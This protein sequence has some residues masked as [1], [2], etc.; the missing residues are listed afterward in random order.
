MFSMGQNGP[1]DALH[2]SVTRSRAIAR[3]RWILIPF[4]AGTAALVPWPQTI[5]DRVYAAGLYPHLQPIVTGVTNL[6]PFAILDL[7]VAGAFAVVVIAG[8]RNWSRRRRLAGALGATIVTALN[9]AAGAYLAF[10]VLWGFNYQRT[11]PAV[12]YGVDS[13]RVTPARVAEAA[14]AAATA[15]NRDYVPTRDDSALT[16]SVLVTRL[17]PLLDD[18][19][20]DL[21]VP[22]RARGG[23]PKWSAIGLLFPRAGVD[24][25]VNPIGLEV[26]PN[27]EVLPFERPFVLAHEWAHLAG[28]AEE[29]EA[30]FVAWMV[31][32][33]GGPDLRY[34]GWQALLLS[35]LHAVPP[36][37]RQSVTSSLTAGPRQDLQAIAA[38]IARAQPS[39]QQASW[40]V[41]DRYLRANR[42]PEGVA[43]YDEVV[44]LAVGAPVARRY[45]P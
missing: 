30:S 38:R 7:L 11:R 36:G 27:P 33:R 23:V 22:W 21:G 18:T 28:A 37:V 8:V 17:Q 39:V 20:R 3:W 15:L 12:R 1:A 42:V 9:V 2:T 10:L 35:L 24:G 14:T 45:L 34:S 16:W 19:A 43:S 4:V 5:V 41:Y 40:G 44:R 6:V 29:S 32:L 26:I 25:M 13:S 31:C